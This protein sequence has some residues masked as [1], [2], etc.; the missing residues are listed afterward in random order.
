[1]AKA[2]SVQFKD[3]HAFVES[4]LE[5]DI[6]AKRVYSLANATLGVIASASL[7]IHA[8]GQGLAQA[9]GTMDK[10]GVKQV[11]RLLSNKGIDV[12]SLFANWVPF[13]IGA[14][15]SIVVAMDWTDFDADGQTTIMLSL[16][17]NHGR[18]TPLLW[19]TVNKDTLKKNRNSYEDQI[20]TRLKEVV[21]EGVRVLIVADR[22]FGDHKL[23]E[24]LEHELDF[25]FVI[26]FR[27]NIHV[28]DAQG[29]TRPGAEWVGAGGRSRILRG[30]Q[31]TG[32]KYEVG[33]V[34]C[35]HAK[36]MKEP[37]CLATNLK[38]TSAQTLIKYYGKR[39]SIEPS[40][41][42]TKDLHFGMGMSTVRVSN[43]E[44]RDR[45][46]LLNAFAV[47]LLTLLGAAGESLGYDRYLK[48][49]TA[50][51]RSHSLF[52]QGAM[53]YNAIPMMPEER[54]KPLLQ[55]FG[56]MLLQQQTFSDVFGY[57]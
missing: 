53:H 35:V 25:D 56:E 47:T 14:R 37:W 55:R 43:P 17:T 24:L 9:R 39:W 44:R 40:F 19:L 54:L 6:H 52:R 7:A 16:L 15:K 12:W 28:T 31:V 38:D 27:G 49:N 30:A 29:E 3:V 33:A 46:W 48:A 34:V 57:V 51:K 50:K 18:G 4:F 26:R 20:L 5:N 22:G 8:I 45:L 10:H 21:P 23:Y 36:D 2:C 13:L 32:H 41:R 11:D 42:D 1:M